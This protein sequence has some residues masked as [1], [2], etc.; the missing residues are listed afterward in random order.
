MQPQFI[1]NA[2]HE[3]ITSVPHRQQDFAVNI[4]VENQEAW[5]HH[6]ECSEGW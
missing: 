5:N 4:S 6:I 3:L 2:F 1:P